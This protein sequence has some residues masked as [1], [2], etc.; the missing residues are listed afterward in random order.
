MAMNPQN[1]L[2][3]LRMMSDQQLQQYAAMHKDDPFIFPLAFQESQTRKQMRSESQAMQPP[4][5]K[6][7]DQALA[8]MAPQQ[9][10]PENVGIGQ[11]PADNLKGMAGG[12]IVAFE[13]GGEVPRFQN[14]GLVNSS[15]Y[16]TDPKLAR[17]AELREKGP[18]QARPDQGRCR[19]VHLERM[20]ERNCR[21]RQNKYH[22][23][24]CV[25]RE[26]PLSQ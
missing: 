7:A 4:Q 16:A 14:T 2:S 3:S 1:V 23:Q 17:L 15:L 10:M 12:G 6:V 19:L 26:H 13:E 5:P 21:I 9:P 24:P 8:E 11:L 18:K 22:H 25:H 20:L